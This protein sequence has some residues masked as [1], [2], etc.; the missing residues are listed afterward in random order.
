MPIN[1]W[2]HTFLESGHSFLPNDTDFGK[3]E[4]AKKK[5]I[6]IY[7]EEDWTVI[8]KGCNFNVTKMKGSF[9]DISKL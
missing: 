3:I 9:E 5:N 1:S 6:G 4:N 2:T 8:I 7:S